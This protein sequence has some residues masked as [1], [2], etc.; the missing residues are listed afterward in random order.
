MVNVKII[1]IFD[2]LTVVGGTA[3]RL[4]MLS[5]GLEVIQ[6]VNGD[7]DFCTSRKG[8]DKIIKKIPTLTTHPTFAINHADTDKLSTENVHL[9][10]SNN[11]IFL[12]DNR[13]NIPV[14]IYIF[15]SYRPEY[16]DTINTPNIFRPIN[17]LCAEELYRVRLLSIQR[18][19]NSRIYNPINLVYLDILKDLIDENKMS[20]LWTKNGRPDT[21]KSWEAEIMDKLKALIV[22]S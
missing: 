8:F 1:T 22:K 9:N 12:I 4:Q 7:V 20:L 19:A 5:R 3:L 2:E 11:S 10:T 16:I 21:W 14:D 17:V 18:E 13:T 6:T 15:K